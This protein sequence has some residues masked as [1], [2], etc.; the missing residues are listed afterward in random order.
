MCRQAAPRYT[1]GMT[2]PARF[3]PSVLAR[4]PHTP[5]WHL[6]ALVSAVLT[7]VALSPAQTVA[8]QDSAGD[9][10]ENPTP[11]VTTRLVM[12]RHAVHPGDTVPFGIS[13]DIDPGWHLYWRGYSDSGLPI[14]V[15]FEL[16]DGVSLSPLRWPAPSY[17]PG[18]AGML[19]LVYLEQV[20]LVADLT[21]SPDVEPGTALPVLA[22][23]E[24]L[25]CE[26]L[27]L[28][29]SGETAM[30]LSVVSRDEE[31]DADEAGRSRLDRA[32]RR[33]PRLP[34]SASGEAPG[35]VS[36]RWQENRAQITVPGANRLVFH[37]YEDCGYPADL[38]HQGDVEGAHL[39]LDLAPPA[40]RPLRLSGI[41]E[42]HRPETPRADFLSLLEIRP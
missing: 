8:A 23:H 3:R 37:P 18:V 32:A 5:K 13:F 12:D 25:V 22:R 19:D 33:L 29:G 9:A 36:V 40:E 30:Q 11:H 14:D 27:C 21:V 1:V 20:T 6:P 4:L 10:A 31:I 35:E 24:W 7:T 34:R 28:F 42:V 15:S 38:L 39:M 16:P 17:L 2:R 41:L 26:E